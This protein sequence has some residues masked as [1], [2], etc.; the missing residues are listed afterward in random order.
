MLAWHRRMGVDKAAFNFANLTFAVWTSGSLFCAVSGVAPLLHGG[1]AAGRLILPLALLS[2]SYFVINTGIMP[3]RS[4]WK[5]A[6][7]RSVET[8]ATAIEAKDEAAGSSKMLTM[9]R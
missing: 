3:R 4:G 9:V 8:L 1:Q 5:R 2:L 7:A 6:P